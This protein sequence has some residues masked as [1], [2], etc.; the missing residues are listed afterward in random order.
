MK[1]IFHVNESERWNMALNNIHN[2]LAIDNTI[3]IELLV[4]SAAIIRITKS[5]IEKSE[6]LSM[7]NDLHHQKVIFAVCNNTLTHMNISETEIYKHAIV[8]PAGIYELADKQQQGYCY[9]KP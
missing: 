1:I 5:E 6:Q 4:H 8:V 9:I 3:S 7:L 2:L